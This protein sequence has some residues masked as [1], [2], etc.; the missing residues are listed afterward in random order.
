MVAS[1]YGIS[2]EKK[3]IWVYLEQEDGVLENV[4]LELLSR[5]RE[6]ADVIG[7]QLAGL[8]LGHQV[9]DLAE[10][11]FLYG[12]DQVWLAEHPLLEFFTIDAYAPV[13]FQAV[14]QE[15][16]SVFLFGATHNGRDLAGRLAVRL[17]TG[18]NADCTGLSLDPDGNLLVCEVSGFGGGVLAM[19][20]MRQHRPQMATVRPGV[21]SLVETERVS[22]RSVIRLPVELN[23]EMIKTRVIERVIGKGVDLTRVPVLIAGGRGVAE[24]LDMLRELAGLLDGEIGVTRPPVDEGL[25]ERER[26][27]GQT[28]VVCSPRVAICCGIS[29]AFHFIVGVEKADVVISINTDPKAPIFGFSDYCIVDD[30]N[31]VIPD[32]IK[33]LQP[34]QEVSNA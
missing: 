7:W 10:Q 25:I 5:G 33:A 2:K 29:G 11:A 24:N 32:L 4:S 20:E 9:A 19:I 13:V 21:F 30:A 22:E 34:E 23:E 1:L 26:Q 14:M 12:A 18:L 15:K 6:L 27:I 3:V 31:K 16:P 17:R 8:L 28:G